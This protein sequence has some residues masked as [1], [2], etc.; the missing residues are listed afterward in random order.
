LKFLFKKKFS[1]NYKRKQNS[2][3]H[4]RIIKIII[5]TK[6]TNKIFQ[7]L[8]QGADKVNNQNKANYGESIINEIID[9]E[10]K[11]DFHLRSL[12]EALNNK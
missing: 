11:F 9:S 2:K 7:G 12:L 10:G 5:S 4:T 1:R 6:Y 8:M 3:R